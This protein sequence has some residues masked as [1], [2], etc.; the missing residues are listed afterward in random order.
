MNMLDIIGHA[1]EVIAAIGMTIILYRFATDF[2]YRAKPE[3][4][5]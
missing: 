3:E 4:K 2:V 5:K 1:I